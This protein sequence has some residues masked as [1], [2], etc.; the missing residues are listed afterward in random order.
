[1]SN[2]VMKSNG[3]HV[4]PFEQIRRVNASGAE[5]WSSREFA[6]VL[7]YS[8]YRNFEQVI[9]KARLACFNSGQKVEDHF[10]DVTELIEIGKGGQRAV[11]TVFLSRYA[12]YLIVQNADPAKDIVAL[13]QTYFAIQTRRQEMA[14]LSGED[15]RRLL[16]RQEMKLHNVKLAGVAKSAG[17]V[18]SFDYA[19]FQNHGY[20]GLYGGLT[21][22]DI[23]ERKRLGKGQDILDHMG[24]TELAANLFRATQTEE[25]L[26][27][28]RVAGKDAACRTHR[29]VGE[30]V[31]KTI[32]DLGGTMP[33]NLPVAENI[34]KVESKRRKAMRRKPES[35][36]PG[37]SK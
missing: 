26:R 33:E 6:Q 24:S 31:R 15:E 13:G 27:R 37:N 23:R 22:Q 2:N 12:C 3:E 14:E 1:M 11:R 4:S 34:K 8:D 9:Q 17:V 7:G 5:F 30:R 18:T 32:H 36:N 19:I 28:D 21:A 29:E 20:Q 16:L 10:V 25:K 35:G